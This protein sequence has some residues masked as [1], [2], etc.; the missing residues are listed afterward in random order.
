MAMEAKGDQL[1]HE[2]EAALKKFSMG[3]VFGF[4]GNDK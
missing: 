2:A 4:G 3:A 1:V